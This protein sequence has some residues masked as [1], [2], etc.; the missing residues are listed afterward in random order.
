MRTIDLEAELPLG[1]SAR[2]HTL[3]IA[4]WSL[5]LVASLMAIG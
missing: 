5:A 4:V 3:A 2:F 1:A